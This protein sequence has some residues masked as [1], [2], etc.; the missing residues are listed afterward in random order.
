MAIANSELGIAFLCTAKVAS[1]SIEKAL[2]NLSGSEK[3]PGGK[4]IALR[5]FNK[6]SLPR[7]ERK[8]PLA[9]F[10]SFC[11]VREPLQRLNSWWRYRRRL[12]VGDKNSTAE[13]SFIEFIENHIQ[14]LNGNESSKIGGAQFS[15]Q[16]KWTI[17]KRNK[18]V[19]D[20]VFALEKFN[21][22]EKFLQSRT[23]QVVQI[24]RSNVS[25]MQDNSDISSIKG[26]LLE[27]LKR[28]LELDYKIH[29]LALISPNSV[30]QFFDN[31][32]DEVEN[33]TQKMF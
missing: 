19:T 2:N 29:E 24:P 32:P 14:F 21:E 12:D 26:K 18:Y 11:I 3:I 22:V 4:H 33:S 30:K 7:L 16:T 1:T 20:K 25:P 27:E 28:S 17:D 13:M 10:T 6:V 23:S 15:P 5:R 9:K 8:Y 31:W